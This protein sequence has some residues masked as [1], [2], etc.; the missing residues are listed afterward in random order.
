VKGSI[1]TG[2]IWGLGGILIIA[3]IGLLALLIAHTKALPTGPEPFVW[4]RTPCAECGMA[5]SE[6]GYAA[7]L[8]TMGGEVLNFDDPGCLFQYLHKIDPKVHEIYFHHM[9]EDRWIR[10]DHAA[11][12]TVGPSPMGYN[13]GAVDAGEPGAVPWE[14]AM[15]Q[16]THADP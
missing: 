13:L 12:I 11:F 4:N 7:Q 10:R 5:V 14:E 15:Q 8:Q 16:V 2:W 9:R 6:R 1:S 3:I